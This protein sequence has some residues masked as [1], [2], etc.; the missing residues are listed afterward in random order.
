MKNS[1]LYLLLKWLGIAAAL[2]LVL[3]VATTLA[4]QGH[5][6]AVTVT[7]FVGLCILAIYATKRAVPMVSAA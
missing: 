2:A 7:A 1:T 6:L 4:A 5:W 3:W